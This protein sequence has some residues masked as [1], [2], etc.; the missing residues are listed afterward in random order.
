[1][2][3]APLQIEALRRRLQARSPGHPVELIETHISWVLLAGDEAYKLK[4][5]VKLGFLDFSTRDARRR[6]CDEEL[7]LNRRLAPTLYLDVVPVTGTPEDPEFGAGPAIDHAV[8]MR[9]FPAGS[10]F[11][12]RLAA[13]HLEPALID[14]LAQRIAD[15]HTAGA[16]DGTP[17]GTPDAVESASMQVLAALEAH[18]GAAALHSVR[19]WLEDAAP[20]LRPAWEARRRAGRVRECHGDL[21]LANVAWFEG[22]VV[23][24]DCIEFDPSLRWIDV[25]SDVAFVVMDLIAHRRRDLAFRFLDGWLQ[26]TGDHDALG[27]LRH[28]LVHRAMV[29]ALVTRLRPSAPR[30]AGPDY[31]A[32][33]RQLAGGGDARLMI[34]HGL[35]GSGK[36]FVSQR[37]LEHV[38]AVRLRSDVE[39]KRLF[40]LQATQRSAAVVP[41]GIYGAD[42]NERTFATL[43][44]RSR[45]SLQAGWPTIVDAAFLRVQERAS[46]ERLAGELNVPFL[47]LHCHAGLQTLRGRIEHRQAHEHDA[48]EADTSVLE[49]QL[50]WQ[51]PLTDAERR[52]AV[53]VD[54]EAALDVEAIT[55]HWA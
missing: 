10:L 8:R 47:I 23:A 17:F 50:G 51:E 44:E 35:S 33:A 49:R 43:C 12:E 24:F 38:G 39:R 54:T 29:R 52:H 48:S 25:A 37:L 26:H 5:P 34:T 36:S 42:A 22:E 20:R 53:D 41:G 16:G 1:M 18:D 40:R 28:G 45:V 13:G 55:R 32:L 30:D 4:K 19:R 6:F 21:H 15:F 46:F 11:T 14:A 2:S 7:R 27:V 9:R 3:D 31:L